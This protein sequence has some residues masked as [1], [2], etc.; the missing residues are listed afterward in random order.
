MM[1]RG[2]AKLGDRTSRQN[3]R[4]AAMRRRS[5]RRLS[6]SITWSGLI[7][8][9]LVVAKSSTSK[10]RDERVSEHAKAQ[11]SHPTRG[12]P[13]E[14]RAWLETGPQNALQACESKLHRHTPRSAARVPLREGLALPDTV[15]RIECFDGAHTMGEATV[16]RACVYAAMDMSRGIPF[17][18]TSKRPRADE[19]S[20][21]G[22]RFGALRQD[23]RA[24]EGARGD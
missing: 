11:A 16:R 18:N 14:R 3:V 10:S 1:V 2:G 24:G 13:A 21:L 19:I 22:R 17:A 6:R 9:A 15:Q 20:G 8:A 7:P 5:W 23:R 4:G 12:R